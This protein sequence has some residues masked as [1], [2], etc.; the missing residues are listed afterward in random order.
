MDVSDRLR[1]LIDRYIAGSCTRPEMNELL[2]H[3]RQH[4]EDEQIKEMIPLPEAWN[5][6]SAHTRDA[7][8]AWSDMQK[9]I[10]NVPVS[11]PGRRH[12]V[13]WWR[14]AACL[15]L[16][17]IAGGGFLAWRGHH[18]I[19]PA[20]VPLLEANTVETTSSERR[21]IV[22][23]DGSKVWIN[24]GS[25][26]VEAHDFNEETRKVTL[27]GEAFFDIRR[28]ESRPFIIASGRVKTTVLGTAFN[29]RAFPDESEVTVTVARGKVMVE[30]ENQ[31]GGTVSADQQITMNLESEEVISNPV[32]VAEVTQW[33]NDDLILHEVTLDEVEEMLEEYY[34][35]DIVF[36]DA[37]LKECRF[38]STF[39]KNARLEDVL[40][41]V[42]LVN[43]ASF[44]VQ[45]KLITIYGDGCPDQVTK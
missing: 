14:L 41:A 23:A 28:D 10:H 9:R 24:G 11:R 40:A 44:E 13:V 18:D 34:S 31:K 45:N 43:N 17:M 42:C 39:F 6:K 21:L 26:I 19:R 32:N 37:R 7:G 1:Y 12:E 5:S 16:L 35:V 20:S 15:L 27:Y 30:A 2:D 4:P 25:K 33:I 38:T 8:P 29:I 22:L 36:D 3:I